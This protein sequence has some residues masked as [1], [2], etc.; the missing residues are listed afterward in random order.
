MTQ[1]FG[2]S[3]IDFT[4]FICGVTGMP[5]CGCS[6]FCQNRKERYDDHRRVRLHKARGCYK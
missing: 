1:N 3:V 2:S 4:K 6:F 5:C